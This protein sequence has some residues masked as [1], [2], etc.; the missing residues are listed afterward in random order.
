VG[1]VNLIKN[2]NH[3]IVTVKKNDQFL[4]HE[5]TQIIIIYFKNYVS[6]FYSETK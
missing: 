1:R 2:G 5:R 3:G 4:Y 6:P